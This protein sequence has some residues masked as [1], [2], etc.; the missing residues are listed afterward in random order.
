MQHVNPLTLHVHGLQICICNAY[1]VLW[2]TKAF[3]TLENMGKILQIASLHISLHQSVPSKSVKTQ[4]SNHDVH[5]V[6]HT[7]ITGVKDTVLSAAPE[8]TV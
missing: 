7:G 5:H 3:C 8:A 4:C 2:T 1:S 6:N